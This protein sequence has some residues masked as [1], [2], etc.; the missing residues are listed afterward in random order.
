MLALLAAALSLAWA[1]LYYLG[2][3][4]GSTREERLEALPGDDI[5]P[6]PQLGGQHAAT[7]D[8]RLGQVWPWLLQVGW[9]RGGWYTYR[10]VDRLLFPQNQPSAETILPQF[11]DLKQG[12][13]ILDGPPQS[14]CFFTVREIE[15][16]RHLVLHSTTHLPQA[17]L[18]RPDVALSWTWAFELQPRG[19]DQT[20]F[21]FRWRASLRPLW[22]RLLFDMLITPLDFV[23]GRSM[24]LGLKRRA[25]SH[26]RSTA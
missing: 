18:R 8:A 12:D 11:Q 14:G 7:I 19:R 21:T 15:H 22:L 10:W 25:E 16:G 6:E 1:V 2:K 9:G 4:W 17:L 26:G 23:M 20:R 3:T 24:C 13:T 5:V